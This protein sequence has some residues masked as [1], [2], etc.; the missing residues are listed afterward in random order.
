MGFE[1]I[2]LT[3]YNV[4]HVDSR[5]EA[6]VRIAIVGAGQVG[7]NLARRLS[8]E[9]HQIILIDSEREKARRAQEVLDISATHGSG[10]SISTLVEAG[11]NGAD[12]L[13]AVTDSDEV[14]IVS[15]LLAD[16][17]K[18]KTKIA[19]V[20]DEQMASSESVAHWQKL[21]ID[22]MINP[23][24][25]TAQ[26]IVKLIH[27]A[28]ATDLIDF[29]DGRIQILGMHL[30]EQIG[31]LGKP[32]KEI[33]Q[34][35]EAPTYRTVA[36]RRRGQTI[37]PTGDDVLLPG[38]QIYVIAETGVIPQVMEMAGLKPLQVH[39]VMILG[40][41]RVGLQAA[42]LLE[43]DFNV[44]I[45]ESRHGKS[46]QIARELDSSLV[47]HGD[48][49]EVDLLAQEGIT[50]MDAFVAAT[51]DDET[52]IIATLVVK[53][54]KVR[55]TIALVNN[56]DYVPI[57]PTIGLDTTVSTQLIA[58]GAILR[59]IRRGEILSV[60][61]LQGVEAEAIELVPKKN[62][63]ITRKPLKDIRFPKGAIVGAVMHEDRVFVPVGDS[64][65]EHG[66]KTVVFAL[67]SAVC[68][69]EAYFD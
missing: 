64:M 69:V 27:Q 10:S 35:P 56:T 36:I 43:K 52:N 14:N 8:G 53:H 40:G 13:L 4:P 68:K 34:R 26:R 62:S 55:R 28:N 47:I 20:R 1:S 50:D 38:D 48:G 32:L 57:T 58:V 44:K 17:L 9:N 21:G 12:M 29:F 41:G 63:K 54:L 7:F 39:N 5:K 51:G 65:I 37:I 42:R 22:L 11:V 23:E 46:V 15:C 49:T 24:Q 59:Y 67:P 31:F 3:S 16:R 33:T 61:T 6:Q 45:I 18:V 66:D 60:E 25:L 19:R 2:Q 30:Y